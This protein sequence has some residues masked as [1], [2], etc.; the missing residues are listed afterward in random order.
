VAPLGL[1]GLGG[2]SVGSK[3]VQMT[4]FVG[5]GALGGGNVTVDIGG[6][7]GQTT[8]RDEGGSGAN[9]AGPGPT[10][11]RGEGLVIAVGGT[12]R[13]LPGTTTPITTGGGDVSITIDGVLNPLDAGAYHTGATRSQQSGELASVN[14]DV[15]DLRGDIS[16]A[17][18]A[19]GRIDYQFD[20]GSQNLSDPRAVNPF[21][22]NNGVP[23]GGIE[24]VPGDGTVT[25]DT[26]RDLVLGGAADPGRVFEQDLTSLKGLLLG[27]DVTDIGGFTAFSLWA[28]TTAISLF[29]SGGNVTP[30]TV[31]NQIGQ[32]NAGIIQNNMPTDYRSV[33]PATLLVTAATGNI[34]YGQDG[35]PPSSGSGYTQYSLETMPSPNGQVEFLAGGSII[36]NGYAVDISGANALGLSLPADPAFTSD[37]SSTTGLTNIR[38]GIGTNQSPVAL[39][40]LEADTPTGNLHENDTD[41]ALFYAAGGDIVNFQ[42]GETIYFGGGTNEPQSSWYIAGKPV[43]IRASNDIVSTGTRPDSYPNAGAFAVQEN[44]QRDGFTNAINGN[45]INYWSSGN[46]FFNTSTTSVSEIIAGRDILSAYAYVGGP[47][48]LDVQAGRNLYQASYSLGGQ[49][50]LYF[51]SLKSLGDNLITGSPLNTSAGANVYVDAGVGAAGPDYTAFATLFIDPANQGKIA[52]PT[53]DPKAKAAVQAEITDLLV[54][55]LQKNL[56]YKGNAD[57]AFAYFKTLSVTEQSAVSRAM[58]YAVLQF[59]GASEANPNSVYYK[60]YVLGR[61]AI[62]TLFPS[63]GTETTP[64]APVGYTGDITM[65]SGTVHGIETSSGAPATFDGGIATLFG[66]NVQVLDPGGA[67]VFGI[68]G[69]PAPG[70]SSGIVTYGAGNIDI[71]ALDNVLLGQSRIFTTGGGNIVIW[72]SSGDINAGIGAKTTVV[73]NPPVLIYD[74]E[75]GITETPPASTSGAGIATLQ[76]LPD[77]PAGD[78]NLIAPGGTIDA[79][80]AGI[81]VSGNLVLAAARV[82]G[83]ANISV[84]GSTSGAPSV[85]VA[86]LG[87]VEAAGAAAGAASSTAQSQGNKNDTTDAAS[88]LDVEV[89]SIGGSYNEEKKRRK[90]GI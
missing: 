90:Q 49:Q 9:G 86:S 46:L 47:G 8:A 52:I 11:T 66:G 63:N 24:V 14:G 38:T 68:T 27:Q 77:V 4:G 51:G 43:W 40:A 78:V 22:S 16:I 37:A 3:V 23:N 54:A 76:P 13:L 56:G 48:T 59:S 67:T 2:V 55:L 84:K 85:T 81:R 62:D 72:S 36:A 21:A 17:A 80:E 31:P 26:A 83:T 71:Y 12:G 25:I 50:V 29:S 41:P 44:Q 82:V 19:I 39:F 15:T 5:F 61:Q 32:L 1:T 10:Y 60:S 45:S 87:A 64:G 6:N 74:S 75:G 30:T 53:A 65:Y 7:A 20:S 70:N 34:I 18:G 88:V 35:S 33:Y 28:P 42:T 58:F 73:Y 89:V 69:G 79:G 57:G